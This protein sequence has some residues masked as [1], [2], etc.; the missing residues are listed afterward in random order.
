M[1]G[2]GMREPSSQFGIV[3]HNSSRTVTDDIPFQENGISY[4]C[5]VGR[6]QTP[7]SYSQNDGGTAPSGM[8]NQSD[9]LCSYSMGHVTNDGESS[10]D[11][12]MNHDKDLIGYSMLDFHLDCKSWFNASFYCFCHVST[13]IINFMH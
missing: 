1:L 3:D 10:A 6:P 9:P 13:E 5:M 2:A 12:H 4:S 11:I 7:S 8:T